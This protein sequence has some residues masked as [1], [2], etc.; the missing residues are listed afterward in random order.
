[1]ERRGEEE[2]QWMMMMTSFVLG[3]SIVVVVVSI[4]LAGLFCSSDEDFCR[5]IRQ[6]G[7]REGG[8]DTNT[9]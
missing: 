2:Q 1:M 4:V 8:A 9:S 3:L 7:G 6:E 5:L